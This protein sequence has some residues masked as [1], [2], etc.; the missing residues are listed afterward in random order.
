MNNEQSQM[1]VSEI[2]KEFGDL[3][4]REKKLLQAGINLVV[5]KQMSVMKSLADMFTN[6]DLDNEGIVPETQKIME[7][8]GWILKAKSDKDKDGETIEDAYFKI[9]KMINGRERLLPFILENHHTT[10]RSKEGYLST[11]K[12][13]DMEIIYSNQKK[14]EF[15]DIL[16]DF[17]FK[18]FGRSTERKY[19][20]L[21]TMDKKQ[22]TEFLTTMDQMDV[23]KEYIGV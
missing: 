5:K 19:I 9:Y 8:L 2:K 7:T 1:L 11:P 23:I 20:D 3:S 6:L 15:Y 12:K 22:L 17:E 10:E 18:P 4:E 16:N 21:N 13:S 14:E